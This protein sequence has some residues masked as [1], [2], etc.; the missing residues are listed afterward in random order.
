ML[1]NGPDNQVAIGN[2]ARA[3]LQSIAEPRRSRWRYQGPFAGRV[4]FKSKT[5]YIAA[6]PVFWPTIDDMTRKADISADTI[7]AVNS[8]SESLVYCWYEI[9]QANPGSP[10]LRTGT[11][12][13]DWWAES[14][15]ASSAEVNYILGTYKTDASKQP[16]DWKQWQFG[17]IKVPNLD[18]IR[19]YLEET[20]Q[21][22][23]DDAV[24]DIA[25]NTSN[26]STNTSN[27]ST[28]T[29]NISTN[30]SNISTNT[31][32]ISTNASNIS[33]NNTELADHESRITA[34]ESA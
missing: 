30:T 12:Q 21:D 7:A 13:P 31:S 19:V 2:K 10:D 24:A 8:A 14:A 28:N 27:I 23:I 3:R 25:T 22:Q 32:N 1:G 18:E 9:D 26:I 17:D 11:T 34:L 16:Y 33:S 6:G 20:L 15:G 5:I 29:T 4:E